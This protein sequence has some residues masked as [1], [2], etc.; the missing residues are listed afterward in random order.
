MPVIEL[1]TSGKIIALCYSIFISLYS[2]CSNHHCK[3]SV[4]AQSFC[5]FLS[6]T[7]SLNYAGCR[8]PE[9]ELE[10][11]A[12]VKQIAVMAQPQSRGGK[13]QGWSRQSWRKTGWRKRENTPSSLCLATGRPLPRI[14]WKVWL[15]CSGSD[16]ISEHL[17]FAVYFASSSVIC[18]P[19][20]QCAP[21]SCPV[22]PRTLIARY[23]RNHRL[24]KSPWA[25]TTTFLPRFLSLY[26]SSAIISW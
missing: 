18:P 26:Y 12:K 1:G 14:F 13:N 17:C 10:R 25:T 3:T 4:K 9:A 21:A 19:A 16:C 23:G 8:K 5:W 22:F 24:C 20:S 15:P 2:I 7:F 6:Q 11:E